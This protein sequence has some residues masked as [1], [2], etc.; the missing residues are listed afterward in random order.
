MNL[1]RLAVK[2]R[3]R[4]LLKLMQQKEESGSK[5]QVDKG[6]F[7][8][9]LGIW[10][11]PESNSGPA[12]TAGTNEEY[13]DT[14]MYNYINDLNIDPQDINLETIVESKGENSS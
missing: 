2:N 7:L 12:S 8:S 6:G 11:S 1:D 10:K 4:K 14:E 9:F 5:S 3:L 13:L